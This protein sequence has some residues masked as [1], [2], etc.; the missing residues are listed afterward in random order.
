MVCGSKEN[1]L[2]SS[3]G[4]RCLE[5]RLE[6]WNWER[7]WGEHAQRSSGSKLYSAGRWNQSKENICKVNQALFF[8]RHEISFAY[9]LSSSSAQLSI[10]IKVRDIVTIWNL[11]FMAEFGSIR[12]F[13]KSAAES[14]SL[15]FWNSFACILK[16]KI[17]RRCCL[18]Y[19]FAGPVALNFHPI[20]IVRAVIIGDVENHRF[21]L[22]GDRNPSI[23]YFS[24]VWRVQWS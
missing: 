11:D 6:V 16:F 18:F 9:N 2:L 21:P 3:L 15:L 20:L 17:W 7:N 22:A 23:C 12:W 13:R 19:C 5:I 10:L 4:N 14:V 8:M 24:V 1:S